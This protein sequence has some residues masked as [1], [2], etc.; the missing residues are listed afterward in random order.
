MP[1]TTATSALSKSRRRVLE[2]LV[3]SD[4]I[5][6]AQ[7]AVRFAIS[8]AAVRQHLVALT[9]R[10]LIERGDRPRKGGRGRPASSWRA[11]D[12]AHAVMADRHAQL[13]AELLSAMVAELAPADFDA[14]VRHRESE[15]IGRY[16]RVLGAGS[17]QSKLEA[18]CHER[19][20]EGYQAQVLTKSESE[21]EPE[22]ES[23]R[24]RTAASMTFTL[25]EHHC[26]IASGARQCAA[27]CDSELR[28]F[29]TVLGPTASV[30]R[31]RHMLLGD[32]R[33]AYRIVERPEASAVSDLAPAR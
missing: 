33:C 32:H 5:T 2:H 11:T 14:V 27:L 28:V 3:E 21:P 25:V 26:P 19:T 16:R 15:Q 6:T 24:D 22:F 18:L 12:A 29:S 7:L 1:A 31:T 20:L 10:G 30:V 4:E 13:S 9:E 8:E 23:D 17:L